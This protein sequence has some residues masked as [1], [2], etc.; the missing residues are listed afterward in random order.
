MNH[1]MIFVVAT[2]KKNKKNFGIIVV[3]QSSDTP[4]EVKILVIAILLK[5]KAWYLQNQINGKDRNTL[6]EQSIYKLL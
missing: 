4:F 1:F 5:T 3:L 6:I 2:C